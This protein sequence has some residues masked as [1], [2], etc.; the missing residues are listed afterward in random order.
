MIPDIQDLQ[1]LC[2]ALCIDGIIKKCINPIYMLEKY[3]EEEQYNETSSL[4]SKIKEN[5]TYYTVVSSSTSSTGSQ[6]HDQN[7]SH[8]FT[9]SLNYIPCTVCP[10]ADK[11]TPGGIINPIS[12]IYYSK[13]MTF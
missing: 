9:S 1:T 10:V 6:N 12:C 13:W 3:R 8:V 11:C 2:D 5:V 4:P 7:Q